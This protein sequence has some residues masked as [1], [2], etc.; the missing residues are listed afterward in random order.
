MIK[1]ILFALPAFLAPFAC[2]QPVKSVTFNGLLH[3]SP[4]IAK[5]ISGIKVG[6]EFN[7]EVGDRAIKKLF[8]QGYFKDI[9]IEEDNG[10]IIVNVQEKPTIAL[11]EISGVSEDDEKNIKSILGINK[12][13]VYD[14]SIIKVAKTRIV[15]FYEAKGYF[16]TIVVEESKPLSKE[17]TSLKTVFRVNRGENIIIRSVKLSG[18]EALDY[19]DVEP[20]VVNKE[21]ELFGWM[22][23]L[24]DGKFKPEGLLGD[25]ERI[26]DEYLKRGYL[27]A[28]V[29]NPFLRLYYDTYDANIIYKVD[30]GQRYKVSSIDILM[31]DDLYDVEELKDDLL[32]E[33]GDV[34]NVDKLRR[35][36]EGME[37]KIADLGYAFV[38][39]VPDVRQDKE[40]A[41]VSI[42]YSIIPNQKV[43]IRKVVI[44]GN[45]R[46][47][48]HVV[49][50]DLYLS[51]GELYSRT[52]LVD[53]KDTLKRTGYFDDVNIEE[54]RVSDNEIDLLVTVKEAP[55]GSIKGGVGYG[56]TQGLMFDVGVNDKNI[57]GSG[58]IGSAY[59]SK[60]DDELSGKLSLTNPRIFDSAYSLGGSMYAQDNDWKSYDERVYGASLTLGRKIGRNTNVSLGYVLQKTDLKNLND[61]LK[62]IGYEEG[63]TIKSALT[64]SIVY[65]STDD[66]YLARRGI[67][68]SSSFEYAGIG[69]DEK[70][71][72]SISAFRYY[73]G[74]KDDIGYDIILRYKAR[75]R[76]AWDRGFLPVNERLYLGGL[77]SVRGY[78]SRSIGPKRNGYEFGGTR[79][80]NNSIEASFPLID[81]INMRWALFYDYG[82]I[83]IDKFNEYKRSSA[84]ATLE[85]ISPLGAINLIF[86]KPIDDKPGDDTS[87]FEFSIGRQF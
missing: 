55:T 7:Y 65:D 17:E 85:W 82:M 52:D 4:Q 63:S 26:K 24:N 1:K 73:Y 30:E 10:N 34:F 61:N 69:G 83:G 44:G 19:G 77:G 33:E 8:R 53:T 66:Y 62:A 75:L 3:L 6:Q 48:D 43:T 2:A 50:R 39:V 5:E 16:D 57:F 37:T 68:A 21:R 36:M 45:T 18:A 86:A 15:K 80:F 25:P 67:I 87:S 81:R 9:W 49:R 74:L 41:E 29:S 51:E 47:A 79:S 28:T 27:D 12:G 20:A 11:I 35:D 31:P 58:M 40:N 76:F 54:K 64:P 72:K 71:A 13:M 56:S 32:L 59:V 70:F 14:K 60:S 42:V 78:D 23:G 84:G 46:T 22:W 38:K